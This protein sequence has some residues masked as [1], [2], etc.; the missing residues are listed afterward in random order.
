VKKM[1]DILRTMLVVV[2]M[3]AVFTGWGDTSIS[4]AK[5]KPKTFMVGMVTDVGGINDQSFNQSAWTGLKEFAKTKRSKRIKVKY[6]EST[7]SADYMPNLTQFANNQYNLVWGI[8]Y[9]MESA[10]KASATAYPNTKFA[11]IDSSLANAPANLTCVLFKAQESSFLVGYIAALKTKTN[12]VG[13][14][15]GMKGVAISQ[16]Q[17]GYQAGVAYG[18]KQTGKKVKVVVQYANSFSDAALGKAIARNMYTNGCDIVFSAAGNV[19]Q[20]V[21]TE[22]KEKKKYCIGVDMDQSYL[23]PNNM[24]TSAMKLVGK[25]MRNISAQ[26]MRGEKVGGQTVVLGLREKGVGIPY[27]AQAKKMCG[28][29]V[30]NKTKAVQKLIMKGKIAPPQNNSQYETYL[31]R[32]K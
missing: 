9:L 7:Q 29:A 17:Y 20:G 21:I 30:L 23:A 28:E 27:T 18:A 25:A 19:G 1:K 24:L 11:I 32:L 13:F 26:V 31:K 2:I 8:G 14:V 15:G 22:A 10:I 6:L 12:Q 5:S 4:S 3:V 16:F